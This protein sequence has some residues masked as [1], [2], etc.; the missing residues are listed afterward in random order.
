MTALKIA[1]TAAWRRDENDA[2]Q[3]AIGSGV[4]KDGSK[5]GASLLQ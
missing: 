1:W 3:N 4:K 5:S 2:A